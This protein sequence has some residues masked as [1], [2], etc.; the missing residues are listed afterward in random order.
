V[1]D[2]C[3]CDPERDCVVDGDT[4]CEAVWVTD[5]VRLVDWVDVIDCDAVAVRVTLGVLELL[6]VEEALGV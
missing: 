6:E 5:A 2:D 3:D 4:D 1:L